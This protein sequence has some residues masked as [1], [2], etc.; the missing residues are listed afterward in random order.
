MIIQNKITRTLVIVA[1][2]FACL[3]GAQID[4]RV[5]TAGRRAENTI[6]A[7]VIFK[8]KGLSGDQLE[9]RISQIEV[10]MDNHTKYRR[11]KTRSKYLTDERDVPVYQEYV[12]RILEQGVEIRTK[13][14]WLNAVSIATTK[15]TLQLIAELDYVKE[16]LPV[17]SGKRRSEIQNPISKKVGITDNAYGASFSQLEQINVIAA[18]EAGYTGQDVRVLMLD[19]GYYKD[20]EAIQNDKIIAE[21]DFINDDGETQN[22][23]GDHTSQHNHGTATLSTLGGMMD[24]VL[25]GPAYNAEFLLAKTEDYPNEQPIEEDWYVAGLEWGEENGADIA[26]SSLGYIDWYT[27]DSL[28]GLTAVTTIAVNIA[29]ENGM[30]VTTAAGNEGENGI[31]APADAFDV[32]TCGA[33]DSIGNLAYFSSRGPT[34][35]GRI[36]P[37]VCARGVATYC[38]GASY[39]EQ[40]YEANGTSLSTPLIGGACAVILSAHPD[41][42]PLMVREA[43]MMTADNSENPNNQYGWGVI[44]VM[45]AI[46]YDAFMDSSDEAFLPQQFSITNPFPNP[47][48]ST[49]QFSVKVREEGRLTIDIINVQGEI[50]ET[51]LNNNVIKGNRD[52]VW[53]SGTTPSG[54]FFIR[55]NLQNR[56]V[57]QKICLVK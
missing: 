8:N 48:N 47:F 41:W 32:I 43:L 1:V 6:H 24:G 2:L 53:D 5:Y 29:I 17:Y 19:T 40:Y 18:H 23:F 46:N 14:K 7:W 37:E 25:Y 11:A 20:H 49:V 50:V 15:E 28:D 35:D 30:I 44:D 33:V 55:A 52:Y 12:D 42:T 57:V 39:S 31:L 34:A 10:A 36:K 9:I 21:W 38:A 26:S 45:A 4:E 16:I 56:T 13:S 54:M 22:E 51:I 3:F 27:L